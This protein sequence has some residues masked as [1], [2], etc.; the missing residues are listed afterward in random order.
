MSNMRRPSKVWLRACACWLIELDI[1]EST[2]H[3]RIDTRNPWGLEH[4]DQA[5]G[6]VTIALG[7]T[8]CS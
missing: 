8:I 3:N 2:L 6:S 1:K 5:I 4:L 7:W